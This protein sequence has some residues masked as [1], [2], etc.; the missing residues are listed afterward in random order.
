MRKTWIVAF[1]AACL[2][3]GT[4]APLA[5]AACT[6]KNN[7][8]AIIDDS[9]SMSFSDP[10]NLRIRATELLIDTQGNEKRTLGAVEFGTDASRC[11]APA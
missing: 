1:A 3:A 2:G 9:G 11:S 7:L 5:S 10:S 8:E 4:A 6:P